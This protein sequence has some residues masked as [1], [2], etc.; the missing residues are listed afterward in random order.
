MNW[1]DYVLMFIGLVAPVAWEAIK[2]KNPDFPMPEQV[3]IDTI[4]YIF[5]AILGVKGMKYYIVSK[6]KK[7]GQS[8]EALVQK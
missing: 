7:K 3:F 6:L 1:K 2:A 4:V 8:Y 5:A